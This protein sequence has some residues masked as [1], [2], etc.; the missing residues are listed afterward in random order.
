LQQR[1]SGSFKLSQILIHCRYAQTAAP[2][3]TTFTPL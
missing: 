3:P 2:Q 1:N